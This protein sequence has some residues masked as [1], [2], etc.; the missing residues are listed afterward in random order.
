M[1]QKNGLINVLLIIIMVLVV[2]GCIVSYLYFG[3]EDVSNTQNTIFNM[4]DYPKIDGSIATLKLAEAFKSA[5]T[6]EDID[7]V[8]ITHSKTEKAYENLINKE[9]DL[10]LVTYPTEEETQLALNNGV[11]LEIYPVV[12]DAFVFFVNKQNPVE[13]LTLTQ[14][15]DIYSGNI[16]NWKDVGGADAQITAYQRPSTSDSQKG[17]LSLVM[18][19]KNMREQDLEDVELWQL[20]DIITDY[21]N[22]DTAIGY[23]YNYYTSLY[24][25]EQIKLLSVNRIEPTYENI[26]TGLYGLQTEYYAIIRKD[27][28][29][30]SNVRKLLN[31]MISSYGQSIAKEAGYVESY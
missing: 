26:K 30:D 9:T 22:T 28:P 29:E 15:Q 4:E 14:I 12:K 13:N 11:E 1:Q 18:Q 7:N 3:Q 8:N 25:K 31:A 6:G 2:V 23:S 16:T 19:G 10:I 27:E 21:T 5:F 24:D 20:T 17:M